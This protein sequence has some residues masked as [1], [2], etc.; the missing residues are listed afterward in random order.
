MSLQ[1]QTIITIGIMLGILFLAGVSVWYVH[2]ENSDIKTKSAIEKSFGKEESFAP[3]KRVAGGDFSIDDYKGEARVVTVW[4]SWCPQCVAE[5]KQ[6]DTLAKKY[7]DN[8]VHIIAMNRAESAYTAESFLKSLNL[9]EHIML[10]L[11]PDDRFYK[12]IGGYTMPETLFY[13]QSGELV[14]HHHGTLS[15]EEIERYIDSAMYREE[16]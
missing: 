10:I 16:E 6:F 8:K 2:Q 15:I 14:H 7:Q 4:A 11:D 13:D 9:S 3:Y 5:L 12:S 1:K